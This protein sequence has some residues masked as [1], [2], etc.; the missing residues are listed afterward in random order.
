MPISEVRISLPLEHYGRD[1]ASTR[2]GSNEREG[3]VN[4]QLLA[5]FTAVTTAWY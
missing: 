4:Q 5:V 1:I 3:F 2:L